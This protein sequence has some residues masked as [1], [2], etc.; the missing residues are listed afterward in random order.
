MKYSN[1]F[2]LFEYK[3][4]KKLLLNT[5]VPPISEVWIKK[6]PVGKFQCFDYAWLVANEKNTFS[7]FNDTT[8]WIDETRDIV[9]VFLQNEY[10]VEEVLAAMI[11]KFGIKCEPYN[12]SS[13]IITCKNGNMATPKIGINNI[14][15]RIKT[16]LLKN[17]YERINTIEKI[18][19]G[20]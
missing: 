8:V 1:S 17:D 13:N 14:I 20:G 10:L 7:Q 6:H 4:N 19:V 3:V 16:T 15:N 2:Y 5:S 9:V 12:I 11:R 18:L